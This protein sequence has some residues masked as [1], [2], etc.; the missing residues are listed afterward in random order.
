MRERVERTR[1]SWFVVGEGGVHSKSGN[2]LAR[3]FYDSV[4]PI[5]ASA[6]YSFYSDSSAVDAFTQLGRGLDV[7]LEVLDA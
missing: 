3:G 4:C 5:H 1:V 6:P 2:K 7:D